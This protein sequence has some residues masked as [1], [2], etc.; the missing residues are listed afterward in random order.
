MFSRA[1]RREWLIFGARTLSFALP[2]TLSSHLTLSL[3]CL[4]L[5]VAVAKECLAF[6]LYLRSRSCGCTNIVWHKPDCSRTFRPVPSSYTDTFLVCP[7]IQ[8]RRWRLLPSSPPRFCNLC[9]DFTPSCISGSVT[10]AAAT[11]G[12]II[13]DET[14]D[15]GGYSLPRARYRRR[16]GRNL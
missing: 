7:K 16:S 8:N 15:A 4:S 11:K 10:G 3:F 13:V 1:E 14:T 5:C 2:Y 6:D 12:Y 9:E